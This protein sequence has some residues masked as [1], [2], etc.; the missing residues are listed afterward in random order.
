MDVQLLHNPPHHAIGAPSL[1]WINAPS[2]QHG[3]ALL[4]TS[5]QTPQHWFRRHREQSAGHLCEEG[6]ELGLV[7]PHVL[8][9][10]L[11]QLHIAAGRAL[12]GALGITSQQQLVLHRPVHAIAVRL[13]SH[14]PR[15]ISQCDLIS[16]N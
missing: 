12:S 9:G 7:L 10:A 3:P 1:P 13:R 15:I 5:A 8:H 16:S 4:C 14:R 2:S 6:K 11:P